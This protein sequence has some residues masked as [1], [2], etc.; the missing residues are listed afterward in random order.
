MCVM[1]DA[2]CTIVDCGEAQR[3]AGMMFLMMLW[4]ILLSNAIER[5][6]I[7]PM[8]EPVVRRPYF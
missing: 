1:R 7:A 4:W 2:S 8:S 5:P 6:S 3:Q